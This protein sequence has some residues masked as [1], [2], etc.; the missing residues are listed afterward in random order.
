[1]AD[2][3]ATFIKGKV[4]DI[5]I[6]A[7]GTVTVIAEN[8]VTGEKIHQTVDMVVLATGMQPTMAEGG[9]PAPF[10]LD[11]NGFVLSDAEKGLIAAGCAKKAADVATTTQSSTAAALKAIQVSRR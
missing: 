5:D 7:D 6:E 4:A 9:A 3:N 2:E 1:M 11:G 10:K 8:A